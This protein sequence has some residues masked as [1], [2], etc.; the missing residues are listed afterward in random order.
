MHAGDCAPVYIPPFCPPSGPGVVN[1][2]IIAEIYLFLGF[3][4][5]GHC[6]AQAGRLHAEILPAG[7]PRL[8]S[9]SISSAAAR[10]K[11]ALQGSTSEEPFCRD[12]WAASWPR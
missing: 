5:C 12:A 10:E 9:I 7:R 11:A 8:L 6:Q 2:P 3:T 1:F 4:A